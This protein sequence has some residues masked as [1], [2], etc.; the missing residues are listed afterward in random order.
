[1]F[2]RIVSLVMKHE[3]SYSLW[4]IECKMS[5]IESIGPR[6]LRFNV[7]IYVFSYWATWHPQ[8]AGSSATTHRHV[9]GT[10]VVSSSLGGFV[11]VATGRA[12][13]TN[14]QNF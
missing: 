5:S 13:G 14:D 9:L 10:T 2:V 6:H 3:Q 8:V 1:M 7:S 12:V 4:A 11:G